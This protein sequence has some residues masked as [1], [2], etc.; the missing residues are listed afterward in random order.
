MDD[1]QTAGRFGVQ[2]CREVE[3]ENILRRA[4]SG[5]R[6]EPRSRQLSYTVYA[7][8]LAALIYAYSTV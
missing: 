2:E 7:H 4:E 3:A 5:L 8:V 6:S 1:G